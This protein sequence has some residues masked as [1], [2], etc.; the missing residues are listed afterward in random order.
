MTSFR[1]L[2][3]EGLLERP[4]ALKLLSELHLPTREVVWV[5]KP[6]RHAFWRDARR[7]NRAAQHTGPIL[8]LADLE[9]YPCPSGLI[10]EHLPEG[11]H[12]G[13]VL[14]VAERMLESW[15]LADGEALA[16]FLCVSPQLL[17]RDPEAEV[18]AKR[19]LVDLARNSP[20][21]TIRS[22]LV[23]EEGSKGTIGRGYTPRMT[24][25]VVRHW[26]PL[27]AAKCS[28]SLRRALNA[29]RSACLS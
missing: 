24:E 12:P 13:F 10:A 22:D 23:P 8:G 27:E 11:R 14:R 4:V 28:Q 7:Y 21:R 2:V 5:P 9:T 20:D 1:L 3:T 17:P 18:H 25:F 16:S 6:G 26:R 19:T 15:L 29:I